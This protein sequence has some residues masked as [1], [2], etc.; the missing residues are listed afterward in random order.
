MTLSIIIPQIHAQE[1][2]SLQEANL[3][4]S[5]QYPENMSERYAQLE[6]MV[7]QQGEIRVIIALDVPVTLEGNMEELQAIQSQQQMIQSA[8]QDIIEQ[9]SAATA[10][11]S[12]MYQFKHI[13]YLALQSM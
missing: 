1:L 7:Q 5:Y 6:S 13:P 12:D 4:F 10:L 2:D 8:Q 3:S 9:L 11:S